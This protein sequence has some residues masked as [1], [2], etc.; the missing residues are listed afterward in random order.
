M[1]TASYFLFLRGTGTSRPRRLPRG[2]GTSRPQGAGFQSSARQ[3]PAGLEP[4][5]GWFVLPPEG[6]NE[7]L[8][9]LPKALEPSGGYHGPTQA[10]DVSRDGDVPPTKTAS[11]DGDVPPTGGRV[12]VVREATSRGFG[13]R[14]RLVRPP[15][16][17][18]QRNPRN[19]P[20]GI[21]AFGRASSFGIMAPHKRAMP[22]AGLGPAGG[23]FSAAGLGQLNIMVRSARRPAR[24]K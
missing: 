3:P 8:E 15:S 17:R 23:W 7:T 21:G 10:R 14:G 5:G 11:R 24:R 12:S 18:L 16:R 13:T 19:P 6:F 2:T 20:E 22:R 9:T 1:G 4:A